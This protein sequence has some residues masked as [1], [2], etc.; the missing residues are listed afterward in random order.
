MQATL[1]APLLFMLPV[2]TLAASSMTPAFSFTLDE[3][4]RDLTLSSVLDKSNADQD[5][6]EE[7]V[8]MTWCMRISLDSLHHQPI[9]TGANTGHN[10]IEVNF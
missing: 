4:D 5:A 2:F 7:V 3:K 9:I 10:I 1:T 6:E 8:D